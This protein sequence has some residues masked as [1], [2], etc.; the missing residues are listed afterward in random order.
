M[1]TVQGM[2]QRCCWSSAVQAS[3]ETSGHRDSEV[4]TVKADSSTVRR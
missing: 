2:M 1:K 4:R 3:L